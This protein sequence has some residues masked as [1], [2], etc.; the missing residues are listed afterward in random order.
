[1]FLPKRGAL[2]FCAVDLVLLLERPS[3]ASSN[4]RR[5]LS[6]GRKRNRGFVGSGEC[7]RGGGG[8]SARGESGSEV[9]SM[10]VRGGGVWECEAEDDGLKLFVAMAGRR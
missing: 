6:S 3:L 7:S 10:T 1:M 4:R 9:R 5:S 2:P 8:G